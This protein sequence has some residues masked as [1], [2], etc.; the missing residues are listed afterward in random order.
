MQPVSIHKPSKLFF[1][2]ITLSI[3]LTLC[4]H[5]AIAPNIKFETE[6]T[7]VTAASTE[8]K[9]SKTMASKIFQ[10]FSYE[11]KPMIKFYLKTSAWNIWIT[12]IPSIFFA[13]SIV[14]LSQWSETDFNFGTNWRF[15][16]IG[17][18]W[19]LQ[20]SVYLMK[21]IREI[22][23]I[24]IIFYIKQFQWNWTGLIVLIILIYLKLR[25]SIIMFK[26]IRVAKNKI[27]QM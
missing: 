7:I 1:K 24:L 22:F 19:I 12:A 2:F 3:G 26:I 4:M 15:I 18:W 14:E 25:A 20:L 11:T 13:V 8:H 16:I 6:K 17:S 10:F 9:A 21:S 5:I 27:K 23:K